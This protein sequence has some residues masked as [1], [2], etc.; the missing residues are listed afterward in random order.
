M[1]KIL[2]ILIIVA[3]CGKP[4]SPPKNFSDNLY[5]SIEVNN[6]NCVNCF[7]VEFN[8]RT[9]TI[10]YSNIPVDADP[11]LQSCEG[12]ASY[13]WSDNR[14]IVLP[15]DINGSAEQYTLESSNIVGQCFATPDLMTIRRISNTDYEFTFNNNQHFSIIRKRSN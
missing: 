11:I 13:R 8:T 1:I 7:Y 10:N 4:K 9:L 2:L 14:E 3:S 12:S 5:S 15:T 6:Q